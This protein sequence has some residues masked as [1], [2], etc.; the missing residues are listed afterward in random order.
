MS[1]AAN[2]NY[3]EELHKIVAE[4]LT[5]QLGGDDVSPQL[6]AQAIKFLKDNGIEPAR[7]VDNSALDALRDKVKKINSGEDDE[8]IKDFLH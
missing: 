1:K 7:D 4:T 8:T 6:I 3:L 5:E 2:Q